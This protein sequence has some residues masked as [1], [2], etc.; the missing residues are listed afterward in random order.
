MNVPNT[1]TNRA[2]AKLASPDETHAVRV[3]IRRVMNR[4]PY[5][6]RGRIRHYI[7]DHDPKL[8]VHVLDVPA[9]VWMSG[10][11]SGPYKE[12]QSIAHDLQGNRGSS[13]S[14]L[15][16]LIVP[17]KD[18]K[19]NPAATCKDSLQVE[20]SP[21]VKDTESLTMLRV[22]AEEL[23]A[24]DLLLS[25]I[26][27]VASDRPSSEIVSALETTVRNLASGDHGDTS[28]SGVSTV[29][30]IEPSPTP[31]VP[32]ETPTT[33]DK[34]TAPIVGPAGKD[35]SSAAAKKSGAA[36]RM[37]RM[38]ERKKAEK[39]AAQSKNAQPATA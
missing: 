14:P 26:D 22:L 20:A 34:P 38:R 6:I 2:L 1:L 33:S 24:P 3:V 11:P 21:A 15:V 25:A 28:K 31:S 23:G 16:F 29:N 13:L 30:N 5:T 37:K 39:Q 8:M 18:A 27:L 4:G 17:W 36:E 7:A 35:Q 19:S 32:P 12:N 10:F 9:S